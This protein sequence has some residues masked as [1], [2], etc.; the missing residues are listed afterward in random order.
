[1]KDLELVWIGMTAMVSRSGSVAFY[2][3]WPS[4]DFLV[5]D[6]TAQKRYLF[7]WK[8]KTATGT[9]NECNSVQKNSDRAAFLN[10]DSMRDMIEEK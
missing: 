4:R 2:T 1:M 9:C 3:N 8:S 10:W 7:Y 5:Q 6:C